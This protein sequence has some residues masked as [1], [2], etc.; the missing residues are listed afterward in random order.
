M[1]TTL[2]A[3][4]SDSVFSKVVNSA[5]GKKLYLAVLPALISTLFTNTGQWTKDKA[6]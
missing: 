2:K 5:G 6:S 1:P 4:F 3:H